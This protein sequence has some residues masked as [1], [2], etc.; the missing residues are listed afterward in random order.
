MFAL[1]IWGEGGCLEEWQWERKVSFPSF[2]MKALDGRE[3]GGEGSSQRY[4]NKL[5][6][7]NDSRFVTH[8]H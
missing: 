1:G 2:E 8:L 5:S 3:A 6:W 4:H 7:R